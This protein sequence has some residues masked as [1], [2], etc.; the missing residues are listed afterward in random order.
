LPHRLSCYPGE[1]WLVIQDRGTHHKGACTKGVVRTAEGRLMLTPQPA[2]SPELN[3]QE[4]IWKWLRRV[5]THNPWW[6]TLREQVEALRNF[7]SYLAGV[8]HQVERLCGFKTRI[9]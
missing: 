1:R 4:C 3:P 8:K 6:A 7:F 2:C 5:V 9:L